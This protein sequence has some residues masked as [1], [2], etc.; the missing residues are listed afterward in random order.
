MKGTNSRDAILS[1][2]WNNGSE[3]ILRYAFRS[4]DRIR[5][6]PADELYID[7][8]QDMLMDIIPIIEEC[9]H[10]APLELKSKHYAGTFKSVANPL[11]DLYYNFSTRNE[12]LVP[13]M[14]NCANGFRYW[15]ILGMEN[16]DMERRMLVCSKCHQPIDPNHPDCRWVSTDPFP[17]K[18]KHF[19][20]YRIPQIATACDYDEIYWNYKRFPTSQ[21]YNEVLALPYDSGFRPLTESQLKQCC[22]P[23][24]TMAWSDGTKGRHLEFYKNKCA[25]KTG[26]VFAGVDWGTGTTSYTCLSL[27]SYAGRDKFQLFYHKRYEGAESD[28]VYAIKD[29]LDTCRRFNVHLIGLDYGYGFMTND[30][31][32][33]EWGADR[34]FK[35]EYVT[36]KMKAVW[37]AT[38]YRYK[39][40]RTEIMSDFFNALKRGDTFELPR[41]ETFY[42]PFGKNFLSVYAEEN[43][44]LRRLVYNHPV[45]GPDDCVHSSILCF[46]ASCLEIPR[47]EFFNPIAVKELTD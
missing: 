7:E 45:S 15:N 9:L 36:S 24:I 30:T 11:T 19:M 40:D 2:K 46:L 4:A 13:C 27:G 29:I 32:M 1:K 23:D 18:E 5:G 8:Y 10:N 21:F 6:I 35:F 16:I 42:D 37:D 20:G 31:I 38:A 28:P 33:R 14:R 3:C 25:D 41:F 44:S 43:K 39:L 34:A 17:E 26:I 47:R 22:S 12:W